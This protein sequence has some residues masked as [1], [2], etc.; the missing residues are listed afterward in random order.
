MVGTN[1]ARRSTTGSKKGK[2]ARRGRKPEFEMAVI[3]AGRIPLRG[4]A[5]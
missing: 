2:N 3:F 1:G 4:A 5:Q